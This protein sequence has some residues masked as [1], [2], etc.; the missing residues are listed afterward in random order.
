MEELKKNKTF[1]LNTAGISTVEF[2]WGVGLP[3]V[4]ESTFLQLFLKQLGAT[5]LAVGLV[6]TFF[7]IGQ[8]LLG[9][10]SAYSTRNIERQKTAVLL[11]HLVPAVTIMGFGI[12]L[13]A[14]GTFL[15]STVVVFFTV[16]M[17]FNAGIG[18]LLP[19]WQN[20][21]VKLFSPEK[22]L[23]AFSVMMIAQ[24]AGR[25]ISSFLIAGYFTSREINAQTSASL[26][27]FCGL[28]FFIG[29]FGFLLTHEAEHEKE[30]HKSGQ[31]LFTFFFT[32]LK[33]V[34]GNRNILLFLFSDIESYSVIAV[35]SF[36]ADYAVRLHSVSAAVAAG[37]F[38]GLNYTGQIT[39]NFLFGTLNLFSMKTKLITAR[40]LSFCGI[41]LAAAGFSTAVFLAAS[42]L[43]GYSRAVRSLVYAPAIKQLSG[44]S[45]VTSFFAAAPIVMLPV[46]IGLPLLCG[47]LLDTLPIAQLDSYRIIFGF[48]SLLCLFSIFFIA[49]IRFT[50]TAGS[51]GTAGSG[52]S[53]S[54]GS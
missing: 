25:L 53:A 4:M 19:V 11:F 38:I 29:S 15:P 8:A 27:V 16:Y 37:F 30:E 14:A 10:I 40:I 51:I 46:S 9:V 32:A 2:F 35:L 22:I 18:M 41:L 20:Y 17:I 54:A 23:R 36:Y 39:A 21:I 28:L 24:S 12:Y 26:F 42:F 43:L 13:Y 33:E 44:K 7:F 6:P 31:S 45:N 1:L 34:T 3:I 50:G 52:S 5:N 48:L 49:R 47:R